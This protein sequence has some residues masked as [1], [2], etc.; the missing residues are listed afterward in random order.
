MLTLR[1]LI[2]NATSNKL[3]VYFRNRLS[4]RS[5]RSTFL[6]KT[7]L[8]TNAQKSKIL[9]LNSRVK[10]NFDLLN[11][12]YTITICGNTT[13][14]SERLS[15]SQ[16]AISLCINKLEKETGALLFQKLS[17]KKSI[18]LTSSGLILFNYIQ[19]LFQITQ[20]TINLSNF[21]LLGLTDHKLKFY[22][23]S[24]PFPLRKAYINIKKSFPNH[25]FLNF[26]ILASPLNSVLRKK[27]KQ[28]TI[29]ETKS[30]F[31]LVNNNFNKSNKCKESKISLS[32]RVKFEL[33]EL[34]K[35]KPLQLLNKDLLKLFT[36][37]SL[38]EIQT[39][40]AITTCIELDISN[41]VFWG[42]EI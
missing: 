41:I 21:M 31:L 22:S 17:S 6:T 28:Q 9:L 32:T 38:V 4:S 16:P 23:N 30:R 11:V 8:T 35:L 29:F 7:K 37:Y 39:F 1:S 19:R 34:D 13:L 36:N 10:L 40:K 3:K 14:A 27:L 42:S 15:I 5:L 26:T 20:E 18:R 12:F 25:K 24:N 2:E 33:I